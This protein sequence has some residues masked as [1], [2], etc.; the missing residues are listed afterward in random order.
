MSNIRLVVADSRRQVTECQRLRYQV[1]VEQERM[2]ESS[3]CCQGLELDARDFS[4]ECTH[5][6]A[7]A[8]HEL[9][10]TVRLLRPLASSARSGRFGLEL[11][12]KF[13]L[14]GFCAPTIVPAEVARYCVL[15][16]YRGTRVAAALFSG[17]LSESVRR[18]IT[19]WVAAAN[20]QT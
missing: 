6:L 2:L 8:G 15:D 3:A 18:G 7:Y 5:L 1:Y 14:S 9:A 4:A 11:E 16:R 17:L 12:S 20:M 10:G 19:H 13:V